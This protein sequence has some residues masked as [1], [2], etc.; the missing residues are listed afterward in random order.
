MRIDAAG[1]DDL[2]G[3]VDDPRRADR[4]KAARRADRG[5]LAAGDPDI[6]GS[7]AGRHH[8]GAAG[9]DQIEHDTLPR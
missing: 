5:D 7:G 2:P 9:N 1:N 8:R 3:R 6:G 4:R